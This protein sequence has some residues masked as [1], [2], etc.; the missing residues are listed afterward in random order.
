MVSLS[1][2]PSP[3]I[4]SLQDLIARG[5][6]SNEQVVAD[7]SQR[8]PNAPTA[9]LMTSGTESTPKAVVHTN[10]TLDANLR[11]LI[12][13]L[14][15]DERANVF[16]ASPVGHGTGYGFGIRLAVLL[17]SKLVLQDRWN[18]AQATAMMT[19][20]RV[21]YTHASTTFAQD[22]LELHEHGSKGPDSLRY[23]V[24]GGAAVP[25]GF[26][27]RMKERLGC[28]LLR[29]Y[30]QTEA[31]M[32]TINRPEDQSRLDDCDGLAAPGV[33]VAIWDSSDKPVK[34][35]QVA[36]IVCRGPHRCRGFY[37]DPVRSA[38][39]ITPAGWLRTGDLGVMDDA[40]YIRVVGRIK[41]VINRRG[42]KYSP[43]EVEDLLAEHPAVL[44]VAIVRVHDNQ[45]GERA[46]ACVVPRGTAPSLDQLTTYLRSQGLAPYKLPEQLLIL[47]EFP[48]TPSGKVQKFELER[49]LA[50][51]LS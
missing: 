37:R 6:A 46:C 5:T 10:N 33:E 23:F 19:A 11:G 20:E 42:Y 36:E 12:S 24:S 44:R 35:G 25:A 22:L 32:T 7:Q 1:A 30:G 3:D 38:Q 48:T 49:R 50:S 26:A 31:F 17:G 27:A 47:S 15:L 39:A 21:V 43:R 28:T 45:V 40:G 13:I 9:I 18:A 29:L 41:E 51:L 8:D 16:M 2:Q 4:D 14:N 34:P